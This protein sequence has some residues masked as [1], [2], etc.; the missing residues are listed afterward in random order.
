MTTSDS[1]APAQATATPRVSLLSK[2]PGAT[3]FKNLSIGTKL[4]I[5]FG[6]LV[7][8]TLLVAT[9]SWVGSRPAA[10]SRK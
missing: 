8:L 5:G 4:V 2:V 6:I 9:S 7:V 10:N 3:F 1:A